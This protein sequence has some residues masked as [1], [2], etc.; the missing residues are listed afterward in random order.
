M[1]FRLLLL[2]TFAG[3]LL[4]QGNALAQGNTSLGCYTD[5]MT[6]ELEKQYPN[7]QANRQVIENQ[8]Q[9]YIRQNAG[10]LKKAGPVLKIP[11]VFH[12]VTEKG[13]NGIS[14]AQ[15]INA[16]QELNRDLRRLDPDSVNIRQ[17]FKNISADMEIEFVLARKDPQGNPT[18]GII[19]TTSI[20]T[21][22]PAVPNSVKYASPAWPADKYFN[23][24]VVNDISGSAANGGGV[25]GYGQFP[26]TGVWPTYGIVVLHSYI[27]KQGGVPGTTATTTGELFSHEVGHCLNLYHTFQ[28]GCGNSC[29]NSGDLV[30]DTPPVATPTT[31]CDVNL[32][33]CTNDATGLS[34][35]TSSVVDQMENFMS[36]DW[37]RIMFT[38]GQK[39]RSHAAFNTIPELIN[40]TSATNATLTAI[41]PAVTVGPLAPKAYFG[42]PSERVCTGNSLTFSNET[43]NG[44]ATS[45]S[46]TFPG[47]TPGTST[48]QNPTVVYNTPGT[49]DVTLVASNATGTSTYMV[50]NQVLVVNTAN[51][52]KAMQQQQYLED[53]EDALFPNNAISGRNLEL[54]SSLVANPTTFE[55]TQVVATSGTSSVRLRN[56]SIPSGTISSLI[57]PN[58]D[59]T[60]NS[61]NM[62]LSFDMAY[63]LRSATQSEELRV[64]LS[65]DC[66]TTW[67]QRVFK[68]GAALST[69]GGLVVPS[70]VP[71]ASQWRKETVV[72]TPNFVS[73]GK[74]MV[75]LE[76]KNANGNTMYFD[77]LRIYSLLGTNEDIAQANNIKLYPNPLTT[78]T[79][80]AFDLKTPEK[81]SVKIYDLVGNKVFQNQEAT[82][83]A[84]SHTLPLYSNMKNLK[85]GMYLVQVKFG[86][87]VYNTKL[88]SQ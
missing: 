88:I 70:F 83:G 18:E 75:K 3:S 48:A 33:S 63:G 17:P 56:G 64:F 60:G 31:T 50:P 58:I 41:D 14:K 72:I 25:A 87:K 34:P 52:P 21:N 23:V 24:W 22:G 86:D 55:K 66:G 36:Y 78:E 32:N 19:R 74:V 12:I 40:L 47:G 7:Q 73:A 49:Y 81:V 8:I 39:V 44:A 2:A 9:Q 1:H 61:G 29:E 13:I 46:W 27:G 20:T 65:T 85:A 67:V 84:G 5:E 59:I 54:T 79:G 77:N 38:N 71:T 6:L 53:F 76:V 26:G 11:I 37:C 16:V 4:S 51:P 10:N 68:S 62:F 57:T 69:N 15:V 35:Y 82:F 80:I 45:Y 42:V 43:Y 28:G 30:C